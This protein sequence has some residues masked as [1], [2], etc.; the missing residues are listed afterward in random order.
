MPGPKYTGEQKQHF[1][2]LVDR[3]GTVRAAALAAGVHPDA[4]YTWLRGAGLT[5][6]RR[7]PRVYTDLER[8]AFLSLLG[9]LGNV[10]AAAAALGFP[11]VTCYPWAH[12]AGVYT[13]RSRQVSPR[14]QEFLRLREQGLTR[15]AAAKVPSGQTSDRPLTGT[16]ASRSSTAGV[17]TPMVGP[18]GIPRPQDQAP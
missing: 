14:K 12:R 9:E 6:R 1:F 2:D 5:M 16:R 4:A 10:R 11:A 13:S 8:S 18:S 15:V 17:S 3:G 7:A